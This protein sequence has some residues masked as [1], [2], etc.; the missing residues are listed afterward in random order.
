MMNVELG[1]GEGLM[2]KS[3]ISIFQQ[4]LLVTAVVILIFANIQIAVMMHIFSSLLTP[5]AKLKSATL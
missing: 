2:F 3:C 5:I 1:N 4:V